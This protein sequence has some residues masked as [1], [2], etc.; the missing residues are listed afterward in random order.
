L[1]FL[2]SGIDEKLPVN[3]EF[4]AFYQSSSIEFDFFVE[5]RQCERG[6]KFTQ[7]G[8]CI[9]CEGSVGYSLVEMKDP[10]ECRPC[11]ND[12]A[13]C[14]GGYNIGPKPGYWRKNENSTNFIRCPNPKVCLGWIPPK[15]DPKGECA[16]G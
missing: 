10:G 1:A 11:P 8:K 3:Q 16:E 14:E 4:K 7:V 12:R 15:W 2:S 9:W 6:E 13:R 5:L